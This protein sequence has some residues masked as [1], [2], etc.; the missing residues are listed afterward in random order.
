MDLRQKIRNWYWN[1]DNSR[2]MAIAYELLKEIRSSSCDMIPISDGHKAKRFNTC[3]TINY[4]VK[5]FIPSFFLER[6]DGSEVYYPF[7]H[8]FRSISK[9]RVTTDGQRADIKN[10]F[11]SN[12]FG[13]D[14]ILDFDNI[15]FKEWVNKL[16]KQTEEPF[17]KTIAGFSDEDIYSQIEKGIKEPY[18]EAKKIKEYLDLYGC[19]YIIN[20]T[21]SGFRIEI[22]WSYNYKGTRKE[23]L[24]NYFKPE[25]YGIENVRLGKFII[26]NAF[27]IKYVKKTIDT[28]TLNMGM[29]LTRTM[30]S[31]HPIARTIAYPLSDEEFNNFNLDLVKPEKILEKGV[32][33]IRN[34]IQNSIKD[35]DFKKLYNAFLSKHKK[36]ISAKEREQ[37]KQEQEK[38]EKINKVKSL[39]NELSGEEKKEVMHEI[40]QN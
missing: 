5:T 11:E 14:L 36:D 33:I 23:V 25:D 7:Y 27:D 40:S 31:F 3:G 8:F 2:R 37:L 34:K 35:G 32:M 26:N 28:S 30:F 21:G 9:I 16:K 39:L 10:D 1:P 13:W 20:F 18:E 24:S 4:M 29:G 15:Q 38:R 12:R 22:M 6:R 17:E 19:P